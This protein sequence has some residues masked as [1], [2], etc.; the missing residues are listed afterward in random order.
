VLAL[1]ISKL[2]ASYRLNIYFSN[3]RIYL[4]QWKNIKLYWLG[5]FYNLF[6]PGAISGD[7]Y[8]VILLRRKY[9]V[10][11]K[12]ITA[13]V[14][15]DRLSGLLALG[16][17][18]SLYGIAVLNNVLYDTLLICGAVAAITGLY[19]IV[20]LFFRDFIP[21]FWP[22][23]FWGI[24]VQVF[25]VVCMYCILIALELPLY[26]G[27]WIFYFFSCSGNFR[28]AHFTGRRAGCKRVC[29]S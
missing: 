14:L 19:F 16:I 29:F 24:V 13:A 17:I 6:L 5:M 23:F 9:Y 28:V 12:K 11:Y 15:L 10:P 7:A 1:T 20:K 27:E 25:Q 2:I 18:L 26:Q 8:K 21:G 4:P 3:I 22:T